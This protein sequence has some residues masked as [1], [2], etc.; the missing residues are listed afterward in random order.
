MLSYYTCS[1]WNKYGRVHRGRPTKLSSQQV[2]EIEAYIR[3][4]QEEQRITY[5]DLSL[6]SFSPDCGEGTIRRALEKRGYRRF[7]TLCE[8]PSSNTKSRKRISFFQ[9]H[10]GR[11]KQKWSQ[12]FWANETWM[13]CGSHSNSWLTR[14]PG[15]DFES[16]CL[17][18]RNVRQNG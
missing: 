4:S 5:E 13:T 10:P 16:N 7:I 12:V 2:D 11:T 18:I 17:T 6:A 15:E 3:S 9:S 14:P 8:P 1:S